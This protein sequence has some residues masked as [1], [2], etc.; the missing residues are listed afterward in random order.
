MLFIAMV[1]LMTNG[2]TIMLDKFTIAFFYKK[3]NESSDI[4][5]LLKNMAL[6]YFY[7]TEYCQQTLKKLKLI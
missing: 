4:I 2:L 7:K 3:Q 6:L 1:D 5:L